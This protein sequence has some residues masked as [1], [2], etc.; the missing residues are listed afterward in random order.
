[1]SEGDP[2]LTVKQLAARYSLSRDTVYKWLRRSGL[3]RVKEGGYRI[4]LSDFERWWN[5]KRS[6]GAVYSLKT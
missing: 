2:I 6:E 5:E 3:P 1:M 4:R